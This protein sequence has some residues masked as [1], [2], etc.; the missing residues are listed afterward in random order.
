MTWR[1]FGFTV[2]IG[3]LTACEPSSVVPPVT[4][5][6]VIQEV[7][8][9]SGVVPDPEPKIEKPAMKMD[10]GDLAD[11][12]EETP[13][14]DRESAPTFAAALAATPRRFVIDSLDRKNAESGY[15]EAVVQFEIEGIK[16]G[17][18]FEAV[19]EY[20][21]DVLDLPKEA[22]M[23][24]GV[25]AESR[26]GRLLLRDRGRVQTLKEVDA[27]KPLIC[28]PAQRGRAI[29]RVEFK[30]LDASAIPKGELPLNV[31]LRASKPSAR[32]CIARLELST[33]RGI[34]STLAELRRER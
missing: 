16:I 32:V 19:F 7:E 20:D 33:R 13:G 8:V 25:R 11:L 22:W 6:A 3:A 34:L 30:I 23:Q 29:A 5:E 18:G 4:E 26:W 12:L 27:S 17:E 9:E 2:A 1:G 15:S 28:D 21:K 31:S 24:D 10:D 14:L